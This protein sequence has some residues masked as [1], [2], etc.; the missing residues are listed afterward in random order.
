M[1]N[2][3]LYF[4][5]LLPAHRRH[6]CVLYESQNKQQLFLYLAVTD[7]IYKRNGLFIARY[8]LNL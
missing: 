8:E 4:K 6:L 1:R 3:A 5:M 2:Q 7:R